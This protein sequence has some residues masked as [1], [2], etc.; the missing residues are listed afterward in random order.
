MSHPVTGRKTKSRSDF[1][2]KFLYFS[3]I[4]AQEEY[5]QK[6]SEQNDHYQAWMNYQRSLHTSSTSGMSSDQE[7]IISGEDGSKKKESNNE[8]QE[9]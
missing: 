8:L 7:S 5:I 1:S 9:G 3:Y 4:Q 6:L 2:H